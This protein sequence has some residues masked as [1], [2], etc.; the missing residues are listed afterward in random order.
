MASREWIEKVAQILW[1]EVYEASFRGKER[2]RF[3]LTREQLRKALRVERLHATT[4]ERLQDIALEKGLVVIDLDDL[5][6]CVEVDVLRRYRRPPSEVFARFF[7]PLADGDEDGDQ[8][9]D[10]SDEG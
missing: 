8:D 4:V 7:P 6:P 2:G 3:C 1:A 5:F 10:D 9:D